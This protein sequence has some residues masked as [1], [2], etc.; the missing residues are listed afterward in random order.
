[1]KLLLLLDVICRTCALKT[2]QVVSSVNL[3]C[4]IFQ[5][6]CAKHTVSLMQALHCKVTADQAN[7]LFSEMRSRLSSHLLHE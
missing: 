1:M 4:T 5:K 3:A 6:K 2:M 7:L